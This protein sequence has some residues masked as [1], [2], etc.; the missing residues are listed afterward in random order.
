M[1]PEIEGLAQER[2]QVK[3]TIQ[4]QKRKLIYDKEEQTI[5]KMQNNEYRRM[6]FQVQQDNK[7]LEAK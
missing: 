6:I 2:D 4:D 7:E 5:M 3:L 1:K